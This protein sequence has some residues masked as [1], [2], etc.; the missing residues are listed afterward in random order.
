M[1]QGLFLQLSEPL[2]TTQAY[3]PND[4]ELLVV[5]VQ[6]GRPET[7]EGEKFNELQTAKLDSYNISKD[8]IKQCFSDFKNSSFDNIEKYT[9]GIK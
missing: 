8:I 7:P 3:K 4:Y 5:S 1:N 2:G 9:C 6:P